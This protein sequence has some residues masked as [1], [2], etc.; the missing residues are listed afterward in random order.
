MSLTD[1]GA[2]TPHALY[3]ADLEDGAGAELFQRHGPYDHCYTD[4]PWNAGIAKMF[5]K[6]SGAELDRSVD[7]DALLTLTLEMV[8]DQVLGWSFVQ[9]GVQ[10]RDFLVRRAEELGLD[11]AGAIDCTQVNDGASKS[12]GAAWLLAFRG[13]KAVGQRLPV[14]DPSEYWLDLCATVLLQVAQPGQT[15]VD[16]YQGLGMVLRVC[17]QIGL[18]SVGTELNGKRA[19]EAVSR[20]GRD[21]AGGRGA[22]RLQS[23]I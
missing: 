7:V 15:V 14:V 3:V 4:P 17:D 13:P 21:R 6:W 22:W 2:P 1:A 18:V 20:L 8:R 10:K 5:R 16:W 19:T 12:E 9:I 23:P 11:F